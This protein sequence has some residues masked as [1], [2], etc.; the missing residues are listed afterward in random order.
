M[1]HVILKL[2]TGAVVFGG[3]GG[4]TDKYITITKP[5]TYIVNEKGEPGIAPYDTFA[6][7]GE[8]S[9]MTF[10]FSTVLQYADFGDCKEARDA[11][12]SVTTGIVMP[13]QKII[14]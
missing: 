13:T 9:S 3:Y 14:I 5:Y 6:F 2:V 11:Y 4:I 10:P 7:Q 8:L 1:N 12:V